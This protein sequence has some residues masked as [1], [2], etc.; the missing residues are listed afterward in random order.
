MENWKAIPDFEAYEVSDL[1]N[2]RRRVAAKTRKAL[3]MLHPAP[4]NGYLRVSLRKNGKLFHRF[5]QCLVLSAF[6]GPPPIGK[7]VAHN[8][9]NAFNNGLDNLRYDT[10]KGNAADR[11]KNGTYPAGENNG[12]SFLSIDDVLFIRSAYKRYSRTHGSTQLAKQFGVTNAC[13]L[14]AATGRAWKSI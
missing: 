1:G 9:S 14:N 2:I 3:T 11:K 5:I 7:E 10:P 6:V 4:S 8:D 12:N 13:I